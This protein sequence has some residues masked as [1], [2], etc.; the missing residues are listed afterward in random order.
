M[1]DSPYAD[2]VVALIDAPRDPESHTV[3]ELERVLGDR[4]FKLDRP[5]LEEA[6]PGEIYERAGIIEFDANVPRDEAAWLPA[7]HVAIDGLIA[8]LV[9]R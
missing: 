3:R 7:A 5:S 8:A 1:R 4:L 2:R 9:A 6:I